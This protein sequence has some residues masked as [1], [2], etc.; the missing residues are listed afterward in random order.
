MKSIITP[1]EEIKQ[2]QGILDLGIFT[3]YLQCKAQKNYKQMLKFA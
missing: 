3:I 1:K 2:I